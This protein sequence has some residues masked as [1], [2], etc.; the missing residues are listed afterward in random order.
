[1][2]TIKQALGLPKNLYAFQVIEILEYHAPAIKEQDITAKVS[3]VL[4]VW[5]KDPY[6]E[7]KAF[8]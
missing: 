5:F 1:M 4:N 2:E 3:A 8:E 7:M 6:K